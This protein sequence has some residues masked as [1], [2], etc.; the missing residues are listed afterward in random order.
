MSGAVRP[1]GWNDWKKPEAHVTVRYAE[2]NSTGA[3]ASPTNRPDWTK[4]LGKNEAEKIT[5]KKVLGGVDGWS[6]NAGG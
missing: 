5:V 1:E 6:P 4:Q 2:Y 3:G